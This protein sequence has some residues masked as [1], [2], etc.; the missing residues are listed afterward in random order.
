MNILITISDSIC[1]VNIYCKVYIF[2]IKV[3]IIIF[4]MSIIINITIIII[5]VIV[6]MIIIIIL[7]GRTLTLVSS[8]TEASDVDD[9]AYSVNTR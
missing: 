7:F 8:T 4:M 2:A 9:M 1:S 3:V 5:I 6:I